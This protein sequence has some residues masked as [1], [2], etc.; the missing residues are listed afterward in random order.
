MGVDGIDGSRLAPVVRFISDNLVLRWAWNPDVDA[1][2][3]V[4]DIV[5]E[6]V[7][8]AEQRTTLGKAIWTLEASSDEIAAAQPV[9]AEGMRDVNRRTWGRTAKRQK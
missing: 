8:Q 6:S 1:K 5:E 9:I 7:S 4:Q 3:T 2:R